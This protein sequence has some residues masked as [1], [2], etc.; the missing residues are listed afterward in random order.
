MDIV[1]RI[2]IIAAIV[3]T[4]IAVTFATI[5]I[6]MIDDKVHE[7]HHHMQVNEEYDY[8]INLHEDEIY[9]YLPNGREYSIHPDSLE[10]FIIKDNL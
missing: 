6:K 9:V 5:A 3:I 2:L 1:G 7:P 10:E 4:T 8:I